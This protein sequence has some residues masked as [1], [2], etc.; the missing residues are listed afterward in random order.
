MPPN[1]KFPTTSLNHYLRVVYILELKCIQNYDRVCCPL[2]HENTLLFHQGTVS[3]LLHGVPN[4]LWTMVPCLVQR[5]A[6][7]PIF[8]PAI[9]QPWWVI[10]IWSCEPSWMNQSPH[11][12][13]CAGTYGYYLPYDVRRAKL[14]G[15]EFTG[16]L[17][18]QL[19]RILMTVEAK[20]D[21]QS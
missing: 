14:G 5:E 2:F 9:S 8:G 7:W 21:R 19:E 3:S 20:P 12:N 10:Q 15:C 17:P 1:N 18:Y 6:I 4:E 13:C 16:Y 11:W